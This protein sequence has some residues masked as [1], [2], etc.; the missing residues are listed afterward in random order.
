MEETP[1]KERASGT[2][3][4]HLHRLV[5]VGPSPRVDDCS[6]S[7]RGQ[8]DQH[9]VGHSLTTKPSMDNADLRRGILSSHKVFGEQTIVLA[10]YSLAF[11]RVTAKTVGLLPD[12]MVPS[13]CRTEFSIRIRWTC[14][15]GKW[16]T[17]AA[18]ERLWI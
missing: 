4:L 16:W 10:S 1:K 8:N 3:R 7:L 18:R 17:F 13:H 5:Q 12:C 14:W 9:Y 15:E 6:H 11:E 2:P